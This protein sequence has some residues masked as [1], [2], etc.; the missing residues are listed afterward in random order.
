M[1]PHLPLCN[2]ASMACGTEGPGQPMRAAQCVRCE[3]PSVRCV[4]SRVLGNSSQSCQ[5][6]DIASV[7]QPLAVSRLGQI[8]VKLTPL[9][10][11]KSARMLIWTTPATRRP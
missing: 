9:G 11:D 4:R 7:F 3:P 10:L 1:L 8:W 6:F 2:G 5:P